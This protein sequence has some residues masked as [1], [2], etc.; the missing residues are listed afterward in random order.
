MI[1]ITNIAPVVT[2]EQIKTLFSFV[3]KVG[4]IKLYPER[5]VAVWAIKGSLEKKAGNLLT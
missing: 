2:K 1:Q 4:E 5:Y 3:G